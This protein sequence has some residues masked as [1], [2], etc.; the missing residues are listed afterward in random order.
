MSKRWQ[1]ALLIGIAAMG[2]VI[3]SPL[4]MAGGIVGAIIEAAQEEWE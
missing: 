1:I 2:K 3:G 4:M